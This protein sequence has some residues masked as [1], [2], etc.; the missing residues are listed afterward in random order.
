MATTTQMLHVRVKPDL[1]K[2]A[3]KTLEAVGLSLSEAIRIFLHGVVRN[4]GM[5]VGL[6]SDPET[7]DRWIDDKIEKALNDKRPLIPL[8]DADARI[9]AVLA[10]KD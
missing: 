10:R 1:K 6:G 7:Y 5:P 4:K 8:A 9:R 3:E 2:D